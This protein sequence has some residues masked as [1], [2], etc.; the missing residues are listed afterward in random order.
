MMTFHDKL[1]HELTALDQ[2][3]CT[4]ELKRRFVV[5][6][7]RLGHY[8]N[9]A[10]ACDEEIAAGKTESEAFAECFVPTRGMHRVARNLG[11]A[12]DVERGRWVSKVT[13]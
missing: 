1:I 5:N 7:Y 10:T 11:L 3:E 8:F 12:L 2:K 9:A 6:I 4:A 13:A